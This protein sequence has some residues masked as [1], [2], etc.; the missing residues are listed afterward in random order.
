MHELQVS[1]VHGGL[2]NGGLCLMAIGEQWK[3]FR[4]SQ[5]WQLVSKLMSVLHSN[6]ALPQ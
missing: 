3:M 4:A 5:Y 6:T 1:S 2:P